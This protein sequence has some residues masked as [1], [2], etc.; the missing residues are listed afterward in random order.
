[1]PKSRKRHRPKHRH[2]TGRN[3]LALDRMLDG[4]VNEAFKV[5]APEVLYHYTSWSGVEGIL[6]SRQFWATAHDCTNDEAE[7]RSADEIITEVARDLRTDS[8]GAAA[9]TLDK[10]LEGYPKLQI[11]QLRTVYLSCFSISRDDQE[12]WRKYAD[13]GRGVCLGIRVL[14]EEPPAETDRA[15]KLARVD[16]SEASL[17][18]TLSAEFKKSLTLLERAQITR[19]NIELGLLALHRTAAFAAITAK[20]AKWAAEQ[21]YRRMTVLHREASV[22]PKVRMSGGKAIRYLTTEVRAHGRKVALAEV[23]IG[24]NQVAEQARERFVK[25]LADCGYETN[26]MEY[27]EIVFSGVVPWNSATPQPTVSSTSSAVGAA[28]T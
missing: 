1:M 3:P 8:K 16:Y 23:I 15:T 4:I 20:Q 6:K 18:S 19:H 25:L 17:R 2:R 26:D 24:P 10:F 28:N 9:V 27:P 12:Q 21:E 7:L 13:D 11:T 5:E 22:E 14:D